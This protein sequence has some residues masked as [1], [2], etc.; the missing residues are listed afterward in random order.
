MIKTKTYL[1]D[2]KHITCEVLEKAA[3][4]AFSSSIIVNDDKVFGVY[5]EYCINIQP[6]FV[7]PDDYCDLYDVSHRYT[8]QE[9]VEVVKEYL[10]LSTFQITVPHTVNFDNSICSTESYIWNY[11][12]TITDLETIGLVEVRFLSEGVWCDDEREFRLKTLND[13]E[14]RHVDCLGTPTT[15]KLTDIIQ[16]MW[17]HHFHTKK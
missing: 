9:F 5:D 7:I 2:C 4:Y 8:H 1:I 11:S 12:N 17:I 6:G 16:N 15:K 10:G 3:L 13:L 14:Y